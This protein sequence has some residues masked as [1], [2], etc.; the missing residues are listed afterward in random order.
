MQSGC[1]AWNL[2][3]RVSSFKDLTQFTLGVWGQDQESHWG[4]RF[5]HPLPQ[6]RQSET[7]V[8]LLADRLKPDREFGPFL[9]LY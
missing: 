6:Q 7:Y 4:L 5:A 8:F 9:V 2:G 3:R 1:L